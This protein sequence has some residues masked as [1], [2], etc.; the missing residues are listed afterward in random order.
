MTKPYFLR[1]LRSDNLP[2]LVRL[3]DQHT[4]P[5]HILAEYAGGVTEFAP[6]AFCG[7]LTLSGAEGRREDGT[8]TPPLIQLWREWLDRRDPDA[9][10][11]RGK[12][13]YPAVAR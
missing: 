3:Y 2:Q 9:A 11:Y 1:E 4:I 5:D 6:E 8:P 7:M 10:V 12:L 13:L